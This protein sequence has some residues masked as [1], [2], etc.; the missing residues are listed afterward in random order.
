MLASLEHVLVTLT[1]R[2]GG[3]VDEA[4]AGLGRARRV[5]LRVPYPLLAP[6]LARES[7][8]AVTTVRWLALHLG[9]RGGLV[10]RPPPVALPRVKVPRVWHERSH[11]DPRQRW[12]RGVVV[13]AAREIPEASLVWG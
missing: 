5:R 2:G 8:L 6:L 4:L 7:D 1:G 9:E 10:V 13:D 12:F 3:P 11:V